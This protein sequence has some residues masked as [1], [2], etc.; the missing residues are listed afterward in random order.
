[1]ANYFNNKETSSN[2]NSFDELLEQIEYEVVGNKLSKVEPATGDKII[3]STDTGEIKESDKSLD[4]MLA[5]FNS[6]GADYPVVTDE[7]GGVKAWPTKLDSILRKVA[8]VR[9]QINSV[10]E[11]VE[12]KLDKLDDSTEAG[13]PVYTSSSGGIV[14]GAVPVAPVTEQRILR[15]IAER[16]YDY[17]SGYISG[18]N[19]FKRE[20]KFFPMYMVAE[21]KLKFFQIFVH[22]DMIDSHIHANQEKAIVVHRKSSRSTSEK[23]WRFPISNTQRKIAIHLTGLKEIEALESGQKYNVNL[24]L[25]QPHTISASLRMAYIKL[26][27]RY[28]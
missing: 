17:D 28:I 23:T 10:Q 5:K 14:A 3:L 26:Y 1:M 19:F 12:N 20:G 6:K 24:Q 13:R 8:L 7:N 22:L 4:M 15:L 16:E 9:T 21:K 27:F 25:S 11:N 18:K 2:I